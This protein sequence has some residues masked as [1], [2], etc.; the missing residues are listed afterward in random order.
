M[1]QKTTSVK[2]SKASS[3]CL[4]KIKKANGVGKIELVSRMAEW[5]AYQDKT[6]Q[7]II[8]GQVDPVDELSLLGII[9]SRKA[10]DAAKKRGRH[11]AARKKA[12][13]RKTA[14]KDHQETTDSGVA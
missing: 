13:S 7:A 9:Q 11:K 2:I 8:L 10:P 14:K 5:L 1:P 4:D 12:Q 3:K 6:L